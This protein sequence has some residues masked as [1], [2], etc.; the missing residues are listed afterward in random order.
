MNFYWHTKKECRILASVTWLTSLYTNENAFIRFHFPSIPDKTIRWQ[1]I[2]GRQKCYNFLLFQRGKLS[3]R[4]K[5]RNGVLNSQPQ[6]LNMPKTSH[7]NP[8]IM[9]RTEYS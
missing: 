7:S 8:T 2:L 6:K 3:W 9:L 1:W 5:P 4:R